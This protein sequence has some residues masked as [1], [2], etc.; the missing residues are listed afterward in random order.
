MFWLL[1]GV[2]F[3]KL[4]RNK[5]PKEIIPIHWISFA[6]LSSV[7]C[8]LILIQPS[9]RCYEIPL[10]LL[11]GGI[12]CLLGALPK[13]LR[14]TLLLFWIATGALHW[15]FNYVSPVLA[16]QTQIR[17]LQFLFVKGA[18]ETYPSSQRLLEILSQNNCR[19]EGVDP[20]FV[21]LW[22]EAIEFLER[23]RELP[24]SIP[25]CKF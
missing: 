23:G 9:A 25:H 8:A 6:I 7:I 10:L 3:F 4:G 1:L 22:R 21:N 16:G 15:H 12:S 17:N 2:V 19:L 13:K 11:A 18:T 14:V 24:F 20:Q 5:V